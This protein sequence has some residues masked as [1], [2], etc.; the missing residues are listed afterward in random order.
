MKVYHGTSK[1]RAEGIISK[2]FILSEC[3][4]EA[5]VVD[6]NVIYCFDN[7]DDA[8]DFAIDQCYDG[9][10]AIVSFDIDNT[11]LSKDPEYD[12]NA[13]YF[14]DVEMAKNLAIV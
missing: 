2:G 12:S 4:P 14:D 6:A 5:Q 10:I 7:Y 1:D 9:G 8:E 13:Y 11:D 3:P